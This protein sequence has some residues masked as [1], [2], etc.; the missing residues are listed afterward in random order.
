MQSSEKDAGTIQALLQRLN[1]QRLPR[2]LKLQDKV[3]SGE[4][5]DDGDVDFLKRVF[6]D[7]E[8]ARAL[9]SSHPEFAPL[10]ARLVSLYAGITQKALENEQKN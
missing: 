4:R 7:A 2:A 1:N 8:S 6:E 5:L 9:A 10:V 3:N